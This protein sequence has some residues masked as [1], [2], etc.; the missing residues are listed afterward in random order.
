MVTRLVVVALAALTLA[1]AYWPPSPAW[2]LRQRD[3][4]DRVKVI[5]ALGRPLPNLRPAL[6]EWNRCASRLVLRKA[7]GAAPFAAGTIT[8]TRSD[9]GGAYGGWNGTAGVVFL[10]DGWTRSREV[11]A[12]EVGHALGF[13][14]ASANTTFETIMYDAAHVTPTDCQGLRRFYGR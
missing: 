4:P 1:F 8:I 11:I 10:G 2:D 12:H 6:R 7:P 13:W 5:N 14:H 3:Y 9:D